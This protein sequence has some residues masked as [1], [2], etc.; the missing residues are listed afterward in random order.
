MASAPA[1]RRLQVAK[2]V[3]NARFPS[4]TAPTPFAQ[5]GASQRAY[6]L[7]IADGVLAALGLAR[8]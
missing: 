5:I 7:R 8:C 4:G 3:H 6:C 2:A 1:D